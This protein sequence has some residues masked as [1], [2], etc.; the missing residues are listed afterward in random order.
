MVDDAA[1]T[2][3]VVDAHVHLWR[4]SREQ[5]GW[6][7]SGMG[8]LRRDFSEDDLAPLMQR[9]AVDRTIVVQARETLEE[10]EDLLRMAATSSRIAGVVGWL[11]LLD[12]AA[13]EAAL[14]IYSREEKLVGARYIAQGQPPGFLDSAPFNASITLLRSARLVYDILIYEDQLQEAVRFVDRHPEQAFVVDHVA[15]PKVASGSLEPW[16][17]SLRELAR[18]PHVSCK[19]SG[20][21]TEAH[22]TGWSPAML[23]PYFDV[24]ADAFGTERLLAGSDWPVCLLA[25]SYEAWWALLRDYFRSFSAA[26][27]RDVF[28]GNAARIYAPRTHGKR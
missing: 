11:P 12:P 10:T 2:T 20:L 1:G 26:E 16:A 27:Q 6:I 8:S 25:T 3:L 21:T 9:A 7:D 23:H 19:L 24:A 15:K 5:Y 4:Y 14:D 22:W 17:S 13:T 28:G 18:R